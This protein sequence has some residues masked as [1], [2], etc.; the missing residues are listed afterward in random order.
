[1]YLL[2]IFYSYFEI[3]LFCVLSIAGILLLINNKSF[4]DKNIIL[5]GD[6]R[7]PMCPDNHRVMPTG[8]PAAR[9]VGSAAVR[10]TYICNALHRSARLCPNDLRPASAGMQ[11]GW[12][13]CKLH[14]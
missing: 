1:M 8:A 5:T 9:Q 4:E 12:P 7:G 3:L 2:Y 14:V 13:L 10:Y 6:T 11:H